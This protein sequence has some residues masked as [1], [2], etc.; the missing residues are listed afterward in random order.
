VNFIGEFERTLAAEAHRHGVDGIIC[1]H[2]H[3]AAMQEASG[4]SYVNCG[5]WVESCT[6]VA[7]HADGK[8]EIIAWTAVTHAAEPHSVNRRVRAA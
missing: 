8:L 7:E 4:V 2:I 3:H 1:G 5:D 6:A